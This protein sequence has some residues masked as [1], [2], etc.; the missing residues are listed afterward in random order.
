MYLAEKTR[1]SPLRFLLLVFRLNNFFLNID[2]NSH[3]AE[4]CNDGSCN[5]EAAKTHLVA[6]HTWMLIQPVTSDNR[7]KHIWNKG[8]N[9]QDTSSGAEDS[10][11]YSGFGKLG[12]S[13]AVSAGQEEADG[14][15]QNDGDH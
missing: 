4:Y 15:N 10:G 11:R 2:A 12:G 8:D 9:R 14:Q 3:R 6:K 13:N 7:Y 1:S 5:Q